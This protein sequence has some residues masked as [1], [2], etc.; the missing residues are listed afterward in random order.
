MIVITQD[1]PGSN[2]RLITERGSITL[3]DFPCLINWLA[4]HYRVDLGDEDELELAKAQLTRFV[5]VL[6][7]HL[8]EIKTLLEEYKPGACK[9]PSN[10]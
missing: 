9:I 10:T 2:F 5:Q 1:I 6:H 4:D 7:G 8:A 3:P